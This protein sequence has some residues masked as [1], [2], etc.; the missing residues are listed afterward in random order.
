MIRSAIC[1]ILR[2]NRKVVTLEQVINSTIGI[3]SEKRKSARRLKKKK[4]NLIRYRYGIRDT[5]TKNSINLFALL[6]IEEFVS[7]SE[8]LIEVIC[9]LEPVML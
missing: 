5:F 3:T 8:K 1:K 6:W 7:M 9:L 4:K 2:Y